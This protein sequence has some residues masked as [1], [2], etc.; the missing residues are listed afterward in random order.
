MQKTAMSHPAPV[1]YSPGLP[2]IGPSIFNISDYNHKCH[3]SYYY[4]G[5]A[6]AWA[7]VRWKWIPPLL[8]QLY[9]Y[10]PSWR[11]NSPKNK[12]HYFSVGPKNRP[13]AIFPS[14]GRIDFTIRKLNI[15]M[16]QLISCPGFIYLFSFYSTCQCRPY[17]NFFLSDAMRGRT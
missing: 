12:L 5:F 7:T 11:T 1:P 10:F 15:I 8:L 6:L 16:N 13:S 9:T 3:V 14:D 4:W 17:P 2:Y